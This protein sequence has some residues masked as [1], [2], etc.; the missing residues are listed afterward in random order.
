VAQW[1]ASGLSGTAFAKQHGL[2]ESTLYAWGRALAVPRPLTPDFM[3]VRVAQPATVRASAVA[4]GVIEILTSNG[5]VVRVRGDVDREQ[6]K[7]T[8]EYLH[9]ALYV[10]WHLRPLHRGLRLRMVGLGPAVWQQLRETP[11]RPPIL[12][13]LDHID[14]IRVGLDAKCAA[15]LHE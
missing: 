8:T 7:P 9:G 1:R 6:R 5:R 2:K 12:D 11:S 3:E 10:L 14:Q 15:R 4:V 13:L